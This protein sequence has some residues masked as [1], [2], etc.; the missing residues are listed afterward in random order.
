MWFDEAMNDACENGF[1]L[2]TTSEPNRGRARRR[3]G[4]SGNRRVTDR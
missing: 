1:E 3:P 2:G 4:Q